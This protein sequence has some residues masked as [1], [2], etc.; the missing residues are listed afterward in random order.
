MTHIGARLPSISNTLLKR[1]RCEKGESIHM[2][3]AHDN[4]AELLEEASLKRLG[5]EIGN[6]LKCGAVSDR[7]AFRLD[8][9]LD[10]EVSDSYVA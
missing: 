4:V 7:Y 3:V 9:I 1:H 6:H 2:L 5:K 8:P 10:P